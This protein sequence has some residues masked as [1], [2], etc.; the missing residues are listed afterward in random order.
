MA[1]YT[2]SFNKADSTT[3]GPDL[4]WTEISGDL[5][6]ASN[7][8]SGSGEARAESALTSNHY[9]KIAGYGSAV[10]VLARVAASG[11]TPNYY[12]LQRTSSAM[13]LTKRVSGVFTD[14]A[15]TGT[16]LDPMPDGTV[17]EIRANGNSIQGYENGVLILSATDSSIPSGSRAGFGVGPGSADNFE[18]GDLAPLTSG[19]TSMRSFPRGVLRG[20]SRG[21]I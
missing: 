15:S 17:I 2:E 21:V 11:G 12:T 1:V 16:V 18:A 19:G 14:I 7:R 5:T 6:V 10:Q 8:A 3:L 9:A 13:Y 20:V 4:T